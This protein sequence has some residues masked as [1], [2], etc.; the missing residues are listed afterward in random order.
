MAACFLQGEV[1]SDYWDG[2]LEKFL[3][4]GYKE[5]D[6]SECLSPTTRVCLHLASECEWRGKA[7][8]ILEAF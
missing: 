6:M 1:V 5:E 8:C 3:P 4:H 7:F 2:R